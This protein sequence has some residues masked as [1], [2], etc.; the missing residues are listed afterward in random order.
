MVLNEEI[1]EKIKL[2]MF[3]P[4]ELDAL[5]YYNEFMIDH[6]Y[7]TFNEGPFSSDSNLQIIICHK[8]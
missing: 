3:F 5:L 2:R 8:D 7:G 4:Q 1:I 6:K